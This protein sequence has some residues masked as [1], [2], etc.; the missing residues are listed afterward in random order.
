ME[1]GLKWVHMGWYELILKLD[2]APWLEIILKPLLPPK[3][4]NNKKVLK[5]RDKP[6]NVQT[7][8]WLRARPYVT[9]LAVT[10]NVAYYVG[11]ICMHCNDVSKLYFEPRDHTDE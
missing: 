9:T 10:V 11:C 1:F 5:V 6:A 8:L 3:Q 7:P 4:K 2:G